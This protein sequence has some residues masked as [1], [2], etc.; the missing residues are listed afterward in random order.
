[1]RTVQAASKTTTSLDPG[2]HKGSK[3]R[4][5]GHALRSGELR[6]PNDQIRKIFFTTSRPVQ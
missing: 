5:C 4:G 2:D 1:M 6:G 3:T